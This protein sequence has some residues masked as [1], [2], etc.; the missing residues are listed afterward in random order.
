MAYTI[1]RFGGRYRNLLVI[2]IILPWFADYLVRIY[3]WFVILGD[4]G[5][6]NGLLHAVGIA[7][8]PTCHLS[9]PA[10]CGGPE[11]WSTTTSH[12]SILPPIY[13]APG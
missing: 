9:Q 8:E 10:V 6:V 11:A 12:S 3:A 4:E 13:A 2:L 1:S 7:R 5:V